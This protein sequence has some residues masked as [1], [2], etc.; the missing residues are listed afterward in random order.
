[1]HWWDLESANPYHTLRVYRA[2]LVIVGVLW[3]VGVWF[4]AWQQIR[5]NR[6]LRELILER[7]A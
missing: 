1:M 2:L 4:V 5:Y 7:C 3:C 6:D